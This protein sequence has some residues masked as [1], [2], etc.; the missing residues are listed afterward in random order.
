MFWGWTGS[1]PDCTLLKNS[2]SSVQDFLLPQLQQSASIS[3]C[4]KLPAQECPLSTKNRR[5]KRWAVLII[6]SQRE[7]AVTI[8]HWITLLTNSSTTSLDFKLLLI[9]YVLCHH[10]HSHSMLLALLWSPPSGR[11]DSPQFSLRDFDKLLRMRA[12]SLTYFLMSEYHKCVQRFC[13]L[14]PPSIFLCSNPPP[15][16]LSFCLHTNM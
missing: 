5:A 9:L 11:Q 2:K 6:R 15:C 14:N 3:I 10:Q 13:I 1:I 4:D 8:F 12:E 16:Q 7:R